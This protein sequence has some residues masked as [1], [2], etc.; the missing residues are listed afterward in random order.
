MRAQSKKP[1]T[2]FLSLATLGSENTRFLDKLCAFL[3]AVA[4]ILQHYVGVYENAGFTALLVVFPIVTLRFAFKFNAGGINSKCLG[5]IFPLLVFEIYTALAHGFVFNRLLYVVFMV[6][7]F[8]CMAYGCVNV[9]YFLKY[10]AVIAGLGTIVLVIQ[11]ISYYLFHHHIQFV[12]TN[13]FLEESSRWV[14]R[15]I[16]GVTVAGSMYRPSGIFLEPSH[17]FLYGF[18]ILCLC[19]LLPDMTAWRKRMAVLITAGIVLSTSGMG[20]AVAIGLWGLYLTMYRNKRGDIKFRLSTLLSDRTMLILVVIVVVLIAAYLFV[21][22]FQNSV[23]R[24]FVNDSGSTAIEGRVRRA[25]NYIKNISGG[26]IFFGQSGVT[27]ELEFNLAG[28]FATYIKWGAVGLILTYWFY[29]Q[30]LFRLKGAYFWLT[31]VILVISFFTAHTHGTFY[32]L[33]FVAILMNGH[34]ER[35]H[36]PA[37]KRTMVE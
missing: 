20:I 9:G 12:P 11:Y 32:M 37:M 8:F 21:P 24:I 13:L 19:L 15:S 14:I 35:F 22:F 25:S 23:N 29:G 26:A 36:E 30:G 16:E 5:A 31:F 17:V 6:W 33:Y 4:P 34:Y 7:I 18:P 1:N 2:Q 27:G 28:F 3:L 10:T